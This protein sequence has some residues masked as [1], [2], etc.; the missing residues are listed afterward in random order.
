VAVRDAFSKGATSFKIQIFLTLQ[1]SKLT[2]PSLL[3]TTNLKIYYN[4]LE[5]AIHYGGT[6]K[7][8]AI[9][10]AFQKLLE[11]YTDAKELS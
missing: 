10:F 1:H 11:K 5:N 2:T 4:E 8:T 7:E 3:I 9:R 6:T